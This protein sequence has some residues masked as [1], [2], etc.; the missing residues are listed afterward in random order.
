M[1]ASVQHLASR[2]F[3]VHRTSWNP[4]GIHDAR[5]SSSAVVL[6]YFLYTHTHTH[7]RKYITTISYMPL[8]LVSFATFFFIRETHVLLH[9]RSLDEPQ[10]E[11]S[12]EITFFSW[13]IVLNNFTVIRYRL[14]IIFTISIFFEKWR[15]DLFV[16]RSRD[17]FSSL[18]KIKQK[19]S[20]SGFPKHDALTTKLSLILGRSLVP[21]LIH[22]FPFD[23]IGE[24]HMMNS[25]R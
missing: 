3:T 7:P 24:M 10:I 13:S 21:L 23:I 8:I 9:V 20:S 18:S 22:L 4:S 5:K 6:P 14:W 1:H 25:P 15:Y 16:N 19:R 12:L 11:S 2:L 17:L